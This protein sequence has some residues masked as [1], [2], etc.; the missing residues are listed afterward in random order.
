MEVNAK[1]STDS[2]HVCSISD[3]QFSK[4][5]VL[6][7]RS[8]SGLNDSKRQHNARGLIPEFESSS[9]SD[10]LRDPGGKVSVSSHIKEEPTSEGCCN[11]NVTPHKALSIEPGMS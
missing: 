2:L 10:S 8:S 5:S 1:R 4:S 7:A 3:E 11:K 6:Q 9:A